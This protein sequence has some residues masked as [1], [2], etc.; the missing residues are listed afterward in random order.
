[1][2]APKLQGVHGSLFGK[3][4]FRGTPCRILYFGTTL[5]VRRLGNSFHHVV[6]AAWELHP[7]YLLFSWEKI[8]RSIIR[9]KKKVPSLHLLSVVDDCRAVLAWQELLVSGHRDDPF[10]KEI[11]KPQEGKNELRKETG[12]CCGRSSPGSQSWAGRGLFL[13][14]RMLH[15]CFWWTDVEVCIK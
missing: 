5:H 9:K 14:R 6:L 12:W 10:M 4:H 7:Q 2:Q 15:P 1:M 11:L 8:F 3:H 13:P